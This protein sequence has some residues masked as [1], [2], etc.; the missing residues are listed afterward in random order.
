VLTNQTIHPTT[1]CQAD[2]GT[3]FTSEIFQQFCD[4][5]HYNLTLAAPTHQEMNSI[6]E[7]TW[8]SLQLLKNSFIVHARVDESCTHFAL[9]YSCIIF[10]VI[11]VRTLRLHGKLTTPHELFTGSK[12]NIKH[13]RVLFCPVIVKKHTIHKHEQMNN[14][15][16]Y[17]TMR[18]V[19]QKG[20][21]G[22]FVGIDETTSGYVI[23]IPQTRGLLTSVDVTFDELFL[24]SLAFKYRTYREEVRTRPVSD[25]PLD[26]TDHTGDISNMH[27]F[28]IP[29]DDKGGENQDFLSAKAIKTT[30]SNNEIQHENVFSIDPGDS[31][32][33]SN[34]NFDLSAPSEDSN[35][36]FLNNTTDNNI[37]PE[38][39]DATIEEESV[40]YEPPLTRSQ[41]SKNTRFHGK[42]WVNLAK[43]LWD[44]TV[45]WSS[46]GDPTLF[47]PEPKG[48]KSFL[49]LK[50]RDPLAYRV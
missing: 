47:L 5:N 46:Y 2:F 38:S 6:C 42:E 43:E 24:S 28:R 20:F 15:A 1:R 40:K 27:P 34:T 32:L 45:P 23:F 22:I 37:T 8:Q 18:S 41:R 12:P 19:S 21:R 29:S 30:N 50:S 14:I 10:S 36:S 4:K 35:E 39:N 13:L 49:R 9:L 11:P 48:I 31:N 7:R 16:T 44:E 26:A 17:S 3:A 25:V 33:N